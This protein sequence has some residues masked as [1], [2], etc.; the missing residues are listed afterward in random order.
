MPLAIR[1]DHAVYYE[2][3]GQSGAPVLVLLRGAGRTLEH[4]QRVCEELEDG[5]RLVLLDHRGVGRSDPL[6]GPYGT[7][8][9]AADVVAVLDA[10]RIE[11]A[12]VLGVSLGGMIAQ[13]LAIDHPGRVDRLVLG[14][15]S[16][17]GAGAQRMNPWTAARLTRARFRSA[18][19]AAEVEAELLLS[20]EYRRRRP[21]VVDHWRQLGERYPVARA[22]VLVQLLAAMRHDTQDA[23]DGIRAPTLVVTS[24]RDRLVP[25]ANSRL[26]AQRIPAAE[27]VWI[28]GAGHDFATER[29]VDVARLLTGF[30]LES[31]P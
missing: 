26:L 14:G 15:T 11:R 18:A 16:P 28:Y 23:L 22:T 1:A 6:L 9:M 19:I 2:L 10:E 5:F 29:P 3:R 30:L 13:H 12:H 25:P 31:V 17:G 4:W 27:L 24:D 8:D 20:A 21:G 7:R